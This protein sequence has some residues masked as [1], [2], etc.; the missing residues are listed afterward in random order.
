MTWRMTWQKTYTKGPYACRGD[1]EINVTHPGMWQWVVPTGSRPIR[2][3]HFKLKCEIEYYNAILSLD[4]CMQKNPDLH[5]SSI[6]IACAVFIIWDV[7]RWTWDLHS[8]SHSLICTWTSGHC[9][10]SYL[11]SHKYKTFSVYWHFMIHLLITGSNWGNIPQ[12]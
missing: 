9:C 8:P 7:Y 3:Q 11:C 4:K 12:E 5:K 10:A 6:T 2:S 1:S